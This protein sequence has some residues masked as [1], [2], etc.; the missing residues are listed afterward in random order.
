MVTALIV[1]K[2]TENEYPAWC[3]GTRALRQ[4]DRGSG[5]R[6]AL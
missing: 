6:H 4:Y 1:L 3:D 5:P 2:D